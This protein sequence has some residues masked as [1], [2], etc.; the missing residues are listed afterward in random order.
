[1][2]MKITALKYQAKNPDRVSV[3]VDNSYSFSLTVQDIVE[4]G[5]KKDT[6]LTE[7]DIAAYK[8]LCADGKIK[9]RVLEWLQGRPHSVQELNEYFFRKKVDADLAD[10]LRAECL[11]KGILNDERY[12]GWAIER[13]KRKNKSDRAIASELM[14]KGISTQV[15]LTLLKNEQTTDR[16]AL[17]LLLYKVQNKPRYSDK[18]KL[19]AYLLGKGFSYDEVKKATSLQEPEEDF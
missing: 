17:N 5:I 1:M 14:K 3:F 16:D 8:K 18:N 13:L 12:A 15:T 6:A 10:K 4:T 19:I 11:A 2:V 9:S 7:Q